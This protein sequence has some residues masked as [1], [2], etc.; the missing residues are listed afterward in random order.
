MFKKRTQE[1]E[2][3]RRRA[4]IDRQPNKTFSYYANRNPYDGGRS[5]DP[6]IAGSESAAVERTRRSKRT[7]RLVGVGLFI[8]VAVI[9]GLYNSTLSSDVH[10]SINAKP[11]ERLLLQK[12][13]TYQA[14][15]REFLDRPSGKT[16][17]TVD[18]DAISRTLTEKFPE[19]ASA[20]VELPL[21]GRS[22]NL[23]LEPATV[24]AR[25]VASDGKSYVLSSD[26]RAISSNIDVAPVS[27]PMVT[28]Q[29]GLAVSVGKQ[30]LP[31]DDIR[32]IARLQHQM[33]G[34]NQK[35]DSLVLPAAGR[36]LYMKPQDKPFV[37]KFSFES[38]VLQQF[39][40]YYAVQ[41]KLAAD[42]VTPSEYIDV[43]VGD[44]AY[45]K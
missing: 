34:H 40:A 19:L 32:F 39:G 25:L 29:S 33:S 24:A 28:D 17:L 9:A 35:I 38:D 6:K 22:V 23:R 2:P 13:A 41:K 11:D 15:I 30:V 8:V 44:R 21:I 5:R 4:Q 37:V 20:H 42:G 31:R 10:V 36:Q 14:A 45:Y 16:K 26:G 3:I 18:T 7:G 1:P 43:R 12:P 27:S